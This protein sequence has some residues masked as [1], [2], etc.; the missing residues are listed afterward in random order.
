MA[1]TTI[2]AILERIELVL[3]GQPLSLTL[4]SDP[5]TDM[6]VPNALVNTTCRV[7]SGGIVNSRSTSNYQAVRIDRVTVTVQQQMQ[8]EAYQAQRDLQDLLDSIERAVIADGPEHGF[9]VQVEKNSRKITKKKDTD[10]VEGAIH[11]LVDYDF[12]EA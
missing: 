5:Y 9:L 11:F 10:V 2:S 1:A 8:F 4:A 12:S 6:G 3:I 7:T